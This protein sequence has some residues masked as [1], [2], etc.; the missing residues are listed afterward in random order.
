[1]RYT[2]SNCTPQQ[3]LIYPPHHKPDLFYLK[4]YNDNMRKIYKTNIISKII[5]F[6]LKNAQDAEEKINAFLML[7]PKARLIFTS[8]HKM[9]FR[10]EA[11]VTFK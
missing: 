3:F 1:M 11:L 8:E 5:I 6:E 7:Y 4:L 2:F 9:I 10:Y